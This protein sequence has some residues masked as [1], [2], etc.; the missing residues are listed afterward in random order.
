MAGVYSLMK[1]LD[2]LELHIA[3]DIIL[4]HPVVLYHLHKVVTEVTVEFLLDSDYLLQFF[5][6]ERL[7]KI[8][9]HHLATVTYNVVHRIIEECRDEVQYPHGQFVEHKQECYC[10]I[11][12]EC[13]HRMPEYVSGDPGGIQTHDL[14]NRNLTLYSAKLR[15][16]PRITARR[17]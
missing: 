13:F 5:L 14:Q 15:D 7:Y 1:L 8:V 2:T 4:A 3:L 6:G 10:Q 17:Y 16:P 12:Q 11:I 9:A